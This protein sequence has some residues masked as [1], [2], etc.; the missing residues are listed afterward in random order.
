MEVEDP[1]DDSL[2]EVFGVCGVWQPFVGAV[3]EQP[4][5][6]SQHEIQPQNRPK[7]RAPRGKNKLPMLWDSTLGAWAEAPGPASPPS[8][9]APAAAEAAA[10][11][12]EDP[13][14]EGVSTAGHHPASLARPKRASAVATSSA[15]RVSLQQE[16]TM[17][18]SVQLVRAATKG[19]KQKLEPAV[20]EAEGL[21]SHKAKRKRAV[22][23]EGSPQPLA[24]TDLDRTAAREGLVLERTTRADTG[25]LGVY[26]SSRHDAG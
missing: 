18:F 4:T 19:R 20:S 7:G 2:V 13:A 21:P 25:F 23:H 22:R 17:K 15:I 8:T 9:G 6:D 3:E 26:R 5:P 10:A 24:M 1:E 11:I 12:E 14:G 16:R